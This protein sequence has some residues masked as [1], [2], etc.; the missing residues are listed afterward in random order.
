MMI[1]Y[2]HSKEKQLMKRLLFLILGIFLIMPLN[3]AL[4]AG[5]AGPSK[6]M[7]TGKFIQID[8]AAGTATF[9]KS[10]VTETQMIL[11]LP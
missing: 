4:A 8:A 11:T 2:T 1:T 5:G 7:M 3:S 9:V 6:D 10:G